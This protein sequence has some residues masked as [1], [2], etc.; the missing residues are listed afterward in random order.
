MK[1]FNRIIF[2]L[3]ILAIP[4]VALSASANLVLRLPDLYK[5]ELERTEVARDINLNLS[6][7]ELS[8]FISEYM[9]GKEE[10]F[11]LKAEYD[12]REKNIFTATEEA[13]MS[14]FRNIMDISRIVL[15]ALFIFV[16]LAYWHLLRQ[17]RKEALRFAYKAGVITYIVLAAILT[18][19][20]LVESLRGM[21]MDFAI[22]GHFAPE[23]LLPQLFGNTI[24]LEATIIIIIISAIIMVIGRA[25]TWRLTK[26][27]RI[28][29]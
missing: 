16:L 21:I 3:L 13:V 24:I 15:G 29:W 10:S 26:P 12:G 23:D 25:I 4:L 8:D 14:Q 6:G 1:I 9:C 27:E 18:V 19:G 5:F 2:G 20:F 7:E 11:Q 22:G 28:F 17:K